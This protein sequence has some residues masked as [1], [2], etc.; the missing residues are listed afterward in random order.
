MW[1]HSQGGPAHGN[2]TV[3]CKVN[4]LWSQS[5]VYK[6]TVTV[7]G[8][9]RYV[10]EIEILRYSLYRHLAAYH[11]INH[12]SLTGFSMKYGWIISC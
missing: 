11:A 1:N 2:Q 8:A 12:Q 3:N 9:L 4:L 7:L 5:F 10:R 6:F